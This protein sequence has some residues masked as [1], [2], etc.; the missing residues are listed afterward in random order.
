M[1][2]KTLLH[3]A[4]RDPE[5]LES[6]VLV[7]AAPYFPEQAREIMRTVSEEGHSEEEWNQMRKWHIHGDEQIRA[8]WRMSRRFADSYD[9]MAFTPPL[10]S[11]ITARTLIVHGDRDPLYPV[12]LAVEMYQ[13]IPKSA[14]WVVPDAGHGP[15]Y[16]E[17]SAL[18][19]QTAVEFLKLP[20]PMPAQQADSEAGRR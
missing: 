12:P 20:E 13:A 2:A 19:A 9:D 3:V 15:I 8:L 14:L 11:T 7:S 5:R 18:F 10:L 4:T 6:M 16:G 17:R 1:G